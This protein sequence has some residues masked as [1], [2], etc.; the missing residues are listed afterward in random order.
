MD[1]YL[2]D[3]VQDS[4]SRP[5]GRA[6][7]RAMPVFD[8]IIE[9]ARHLIPGTHVGVCI[10]D[11]TG[12]LTTL[13][14]TDPLVFALD[15]MQCALDEGPSVTAVGQGHTVIID[16]A[17]SEHRWP[18]FMPHAVSLGLRSYLGVPIGVDD[19]ILGCLNLYLRTL[20]HLDSDLLA[21]AGVFAAQAA[22]ALSQSRRENNLVVALESSRT[23]G[24]AIGLTMQRLNLHSEEAFAYLASLS[25]RSNVKLRD[26]AARLVQE[27][28]DLGRATP[29]TARSDEPESPVMTLRP[30]FE[31]LGDPDLDTG[32]APDH[33]PQGPQSA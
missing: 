9:A 22:V 25:Q 5:P 29:T 24:T 3:A 14:G 32:A 27:S 13:T 10:A 28:D 23:I 8:S 33:Q 6:G 26:V 2:F 11:S 30:H 1:T 17:E 7:E 4:A 18:S 20:K 19:Q 31:L 21:H 15:D 12:I 16:D